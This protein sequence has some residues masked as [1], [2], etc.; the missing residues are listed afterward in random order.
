MSNYLLLIFILHI[1]YLV[2]LFW[3][4]F[5]KYGNALDF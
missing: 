1:Y 4:K 2:Y 3:K 5:P